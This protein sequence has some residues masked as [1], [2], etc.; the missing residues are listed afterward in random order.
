MKEQ[1]Y[2][3]PL[4]DAFNT[5]DECPFCHIHRSLEQ[6]AIEFVLG[7]GASYMED[8]VRAETD[9]LG[10]CSYHYEKMF[11]YGN[12]LGNALILET[13]M[14]KLTAGLK[15]ETAHYTPNARP[16]LLSR[17]S[18]SSGDSEKKSNL[19]HWLSE[20]ESHCYIC[21]YIEKIYQRYIDTF[22]EMYKK[23][24]AFRDKVKNSRGFCLHH[25]KDLVQAAEEKMN[26]KDRTAFFEMLFP[27]MIQGLERITEDVEWFQ[28]KFDY[29]FKDADWKNSKDAVQRAMQK[30][31]GGYPADPPFQAK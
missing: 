28:K 18:R 26:E 29:Q 9:K 27:Q 2:T 13:H 16:S 15:A 3:I 25:F 14:K 22:F 24:S 11:T 30:V 17:F 19:V 1:L 20:Q 10:F 7:S 23:D 21:D 4:N 5:G 6:H 31:A 12:K 8:D